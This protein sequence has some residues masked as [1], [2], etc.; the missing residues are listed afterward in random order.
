MNRA[1]LECLAQIEHHLRVERIG[2]ASLSVGASSVSFQAQVLTHLPFIQ[3][4]C[5]KTSSA[6]GRVVS[7][8]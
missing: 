7:G 2:Q 1:I 8:S 3:S 5:G 4:R 6:M